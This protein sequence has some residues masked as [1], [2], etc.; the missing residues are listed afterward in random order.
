MGELL[1]AAPPSSIDSHRR[2]A[3]ATAG[4][5]GGSM[6]RTKTGGGS[7]YWEVLPRAPTQCVAIPTVGVS[8]KAVAFH[9]RSIRGRG[10]GASPESALAGVCQIGVETQQ[11]QQQITFRTA[12]HD[13]R[14]HTSPVD[15]HATAL[16]AISKQWSRHSVWHDMLDPD[17]EGKWQP[18][19]NQQQIDSSCARSWRE[20]AVDLRAPTVLGAL[21]EELCYC[22]R[23]RHDHIDRRPWS[24]LLPGRWRQLLLP[25]P[26][27]QVLLG[28]QLAHVDGLIRRWCGRRVPFR[29]RHF[30]VRHRFLVRCPQ[31]VIQGGA[32]ERAKD[33]GFQSQARR[34]RCAT[35]RAQMLASASGQPPRAELDGRVVEE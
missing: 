18:S 21:S 5:T 33:Q 8:Y 15:A 11:H 10:T 28:W 24:L 22:E 3:S 26:S 32:G 20:E 4:S 1:A 31:L 29:R 35:L 7:F 30:A 25:A 23:A 2:T 14:R 17:L 13:P 27:R 16:N 19:S 6:V 9:L 12:R 34:P